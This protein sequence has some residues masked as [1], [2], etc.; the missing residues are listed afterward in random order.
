MDGAARQPIKL[1]MGSWV[2]PTVWLLGG[3]P[4]CAKPN[5]SLWVFNQLQISFST[6]REKKNN[7]GRAGATSSKG[8]SRTDR[9]D[10]TDHEGKSALPIL[11]P[12]RPFPIGN[13]PFARFQQ[14]Q[15]S[16]QTRVLTSVSKLFRCGLPLA[17]WLSS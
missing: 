9:T 12:G 5:W 15:L 1:P 3:N 6:R 2:R 16:G 10:R 14:P 11:L 4:L 17:L 13:W 8:K 7:S